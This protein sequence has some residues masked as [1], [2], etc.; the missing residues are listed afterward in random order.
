MI[1]LG[2]RE[3][4]LDPKVFWKLTPVE[5]LVKL[6][7]DSAKPALSRVRLDELARAYPDKKK[8]I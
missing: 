1:R 3:L 5:L 8:E 7:M 4:G 6:G 2:L